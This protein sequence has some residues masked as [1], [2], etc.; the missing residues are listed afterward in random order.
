MPVLE[1]DFLIIG[2]GSAG[3]VLAH[4][5]SS[6]FGVRVLLVE[7]GRD[8]PPD[9]VEPDLLSSYPRA[10]YF[11][12]KNTWSNLKV[13]ITSPPHNQP[14]LPS[15]ITRYE[16]A[17]VIGGGSS[18]NDMQ[19]NRGI[20]LDYDEWEAQGASG[21]SWS[22]VLPYFIKLERDMDF[23]GPLHGKDGRIP[24]RRIQRNVW[25]D[26]SKSVADSFAGA[27]YEALQD[28]NAQFT[29]GY[30]PIS[31]SNAYDRRVSASTAYLDNSTR[32]RKN[33]TILTNVTVQR[34]VVEGHTVRG[35]EANTAAGPVRIS[36]R[37]TIVSAGAIHSPALLMRAGIG[38]GGDLQKIGVSV[39]A[40]R[41]GVGRNLNEHPALSLSGWIK[42]FARLPNSL[43]RH[44]HVALRYSSGVQDCGPSDMYMFGLSKSGWHPVGKQLGSL[45]A[46]VNKSYSRGRVTLSTSDPAAEP[47]VNFDMLSDYRD[48]ERLKLAVRFAGR[49][50]ETPQMQAVTSDTFPSSYSERVRD[51]NRVTTKNKV[52][53]SILASCLDGPH[54]FRRQ[55]LR[56]LVVEGP[57]IEHVL[58]DDDVLEQFVRGAVHGVW[59]ASGTCRMGRFD[60][61][62]AV[63]ASDGRVHGVDGLRVIDASI[64]PAVPR[65]NTNIPTIMIA[66]KMSDAI[67]TQ[68][69]GQGAGKCPA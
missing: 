59:H 42:P 49:L 17:R 19:A 61:N 13:A 39:M 33:L 20:P 69:R 37:E 60:D 25:P 4:R 31:I 30:F 35:A 55:L 48:L 3:C 63:V 2:G 6:D 27:G 22:D 26:F 38:P 68:W 64:M 5:L 45:V 53:T 15:R 1:C 44:I 16:Q 28:Q 23:T 41:S 32:Q 62:E 43:T 52:L 66:E 36:A 65:A 11:D 50:F 56:R 8:Q 51:L 40:D 24:V 54:W 21:W 14:Q 47:D 9:Q 58:A 18:I 7:A 12:P 34:L 29:D 67:L 57:Q 46:F 10:A